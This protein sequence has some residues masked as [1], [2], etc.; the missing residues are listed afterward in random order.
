MFVFLLFLSDL[1]ICAITL[2]LVGETTIFQFV[3]DAVGDLQNAVKCAVGQ[4]NDE[5]PSGMLRVFMSFHYFLGNYRALSESLGVLFEPQATLNPNKTLTIQFELKNCQKYWAAVWIRISL[6]NE[7][8]NRKNILKIP[9]DC[10]MKSE[11]IFSL[12]LPLTDESSCMFPL[13]EMIECK[14]YSVEIIPVYLTLQ[15]QSSSVEITVPPEV[16]SSNALFFQIII[17]LQFFFYFLCYHFKLTGNSMDLVSF[18][19]ISLQNSTHILGLKW[20]TQSDDCGS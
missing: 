10:M 11:N 16:I 7:Q 14:V 13:V 20:T 9:K 4:F 5:I 18:E 3:K 17:K 6:R 19:R 15:G 1:E 8:A 12:T 2:S